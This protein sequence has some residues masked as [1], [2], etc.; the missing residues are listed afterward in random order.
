MTTNDLTTEQTDILR[1]L[2]AKVHLGA[3]K[4]NYAMKKYVEQKNSSGNYIFNLSETYNK[5]K[6]AAR[7][8]ASIK[9]LSEVIVSIVLCR[10]YAPRIRDSE[11]STNSASTLVPLLPPPAVGSQVL[12][13]IRPPRSSRNP[14]W[15]LLRIPSATSRPSSKLATLAFPLLLCA[16]LTHHSISLT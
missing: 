4:I 6:L 11:P 14:D 5:I 12:S 3:E 2:S 1:L 9:N 10:S 7:I 13:P 8:I 16:T 15:S